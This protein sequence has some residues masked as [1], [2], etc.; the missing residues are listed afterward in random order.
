VPLNDLDRLG[1]LSMD[2]PRIPITPVTRHQHD[3]PEGAQQ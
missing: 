3:T 2:K 1:E